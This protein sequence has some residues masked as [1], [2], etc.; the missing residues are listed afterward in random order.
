M[1]NELRKLLLLMCVEAVGP[2]EKQETL[3]NSTA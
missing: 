1:E 3:R 2:E